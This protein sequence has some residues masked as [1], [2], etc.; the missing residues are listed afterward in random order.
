[1]A[2]M[3]RHGDGGVTK[4]RDGRL[5]VSI[6]LTTGRRIYRTVPRLTDAKRQRELA[7]RARRELVAMREAE[8]DPAGQTLADYLHSWLDRM[9]SAHNAR[10][11]PN[12]LAFYRVI[13]DKH[14]IP[15]LGE[16][17]LENLRERHVQAW[18]D[19]LTVSPQY[20]SHCRAFLRRVLNVA[21]RE[22]IIGRNPAIA[23]ELPPIP[24]YKAKTMSAADVH[25]LLS[26]TATDR[27]GALWRLAVVS[28]LRVGE[29]LALSWDDVDLGGN[30]DRVARQTG[31]PERLRA[32]AVGL[33]TSPGADPAARVRPASV[34]RAGADGVGDVLVVQNQGRPSHPSITVTAR[35]A[36][37]NGEWVR[38]KT[39]AARDLERIAIDTDTARLLETHRIRQAS[40]RRPDWPYW[41]L[42]FTTANGYPLERHGVMTAFREA[43]DRAGIERRRVHDI[44]HSNNEI[45]R[46]LG[47]DRETRKARHGH[48][49]D[50]ADKRYGRASEA[51]DRM[52]VER[53]AEAIG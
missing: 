16:H 19:G 51:Q 18:L 32:G 22:R 21:Y 10:L 3:G 13:A 43:C 50:A 26:V 15:V 52:A 45:M 41:G 38:A 2:T 44:R 20:V 25:S 17:R 14:T 24:R 36:R 28:G 27:L 7:E 35:L 29:L 31:T 39:K 49:S 5:Q 46:E 30:D 12:T 40:E 1:M 11:R 9:A 42:V 53:L 8:L 34:R 4:R 33:R 37:E 47:I 48:A 6:T 23:V